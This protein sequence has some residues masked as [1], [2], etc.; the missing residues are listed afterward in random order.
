MYKYIQK[1]TLTTLS[2]IGCKNRTDHVE[3]L[4]YEY[5]NN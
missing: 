2:M 3:E 4:F 5:D 1:P